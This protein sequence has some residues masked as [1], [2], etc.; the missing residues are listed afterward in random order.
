MRRP[1]VPDR[2]PGMVMRAPMA[3]RSALALESAGAGAMCR[4][5]MDTSLPLRPDLTFP[6]LPR[7]PAAV[8]A[9]LEALESLL[10]RAILLPGINRRV[11]L[12]ALV[13]LIPGIGDLVGAMLG[14]W[15]IWEARN[16]GASRWLLARM[17]ANTAFDA[18]LGVVPVAGDV[19]D[20]AFRS[21]SRNLRL[22]K[23]HLDRVHPAGAVLEARR[24]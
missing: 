23:R 10:E 7:D 14:A 11:G 2:A 19:A 4:R 13:G 3:V 9:R 6:A 21:N 22:L 16:L 15:L 20:L 8:R 18:V 24:A 12:D 1:A 17:A 5:A